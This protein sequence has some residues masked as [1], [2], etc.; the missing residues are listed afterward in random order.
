MAVF[1]RHEGNLH[2][3]QDLNLVGVVTR[4]GQ[5]SGRLAPRRTA[6]QGHHQSG[7][8]MP[9]PPTPMNELD[10]S[11]AGLQ[12]DHD[13]RDPVQKQNELPEG[14][15]DKQHGVQNPPKEEQKGEQRKQP[16]QQF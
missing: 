12:D 4:P 3:E 1:R 11:K 10:Q 14:V 2:V 5:A 16:G 6:E 8:N 9:K 15:K 13:P 7:V